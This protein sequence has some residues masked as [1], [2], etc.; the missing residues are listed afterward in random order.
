MSIGL[1]TVLLA[2]VLVVAF[3]AC[4]WGGH[5]LAHHYNDRA[6]I[7]AA[8]VVSCSV[9]APMALASHLG[10]LHGWLAPLVLAAVCGGGLLAGYQRHA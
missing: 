2:A 1:W 10:M 7:G 6:E 5:T 3:A 8:L 9:V 4:R